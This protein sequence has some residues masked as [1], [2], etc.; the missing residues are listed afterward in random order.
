MKETLVEYLT[1]EKGYSTTNDNT[2]LRRPDDSIVARLQGDK[3]R[4]NPTQQEMSHYTINSGRGLPS[5]LCYAD[6]TN[7]SHK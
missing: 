4:T 7:I 5:L 2:L 1:L 3:W 6:L